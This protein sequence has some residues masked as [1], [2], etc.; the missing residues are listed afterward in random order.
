M[1]YSIIDCFMISFLC[2]IIFGTIYEVFRIIRRMLNIKP[3]VFICDITFFILAGF[4]VLSLSLYLGN[5]IRI[6]TIL[7]FGAGVFSYIC[8]V[9]RIMSLLETQIIRFW[10]ATVGALIK[11]FSNF[12]RNISGR[13]AHKTNILF[14]DI[15][16]FF[17]NTKKKISSLLQI[18]TKKLYNNSNVINIER[19]GENNVIQAKVRRGR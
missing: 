2:G 18:N 11:H 4:F 10:N 6:Y 17:D 14:R 3:L 9:G 12:A 13:F 5:Y 7:G 8:T 19:S 1:N 15:Y 16:D